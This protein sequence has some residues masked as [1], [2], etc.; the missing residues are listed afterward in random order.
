MAKVKFFPPPKHITDEDYA[1]E[2]AYARRIIPQRG[3]IW[4][5]ARKCIEAGDLG[6]GAISRML[7]EGVLVPNEDPEKGYVLPSHGEEPQ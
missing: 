3:Y 7:A 5:G 4:E 2:V 6:D 1:L